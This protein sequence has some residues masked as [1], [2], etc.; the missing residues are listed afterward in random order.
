VRPAWILGYQYGRCR[1]LDAEGREGLR[2][3]R[4]P[5]T[6]PAKP[7]GALHPPAGP[8][9]RRPRLRRHVCHPIRREA[10][11]FLL[12]RRGFTFQRTRPWKQSTGLDYGAGL[13]RISTR[14]AGRQGLPQKGD[15]QIGDVR[16]PLQAGKVTCPRQ[17][18]MVGVREQVR[19]H[20]SDLPE[21]RHIMAA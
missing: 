16:G 15:Q 6:G 3:L 4:R 12:A 5:P 17:F 14:S 9:V 21:V 11:R 1:L 13:G 20:G 18:D 10:V 7:G 8:E 2:H 19:Q